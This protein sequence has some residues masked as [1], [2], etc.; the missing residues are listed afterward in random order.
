MTDTYKSWFE[1]LRD[2]RV[3]SRIVMRIRRLETGNLGDVKPVGE[4]VHE[5]R[6][7]YGQGYRI[8]F[9]NEN[10]EI[11]ILLVGGDKSSQQRDIKQARALLK[12]LHENGAD[13]G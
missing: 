7:D 4:G 1:K 9:A 12:E 10:G 5:L 6:I 2:V 3:K 11:I 8:Y 13:N